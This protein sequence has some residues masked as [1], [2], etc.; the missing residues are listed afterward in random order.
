LC[1]RLSEGIG[2]VRWRKK[3]GRENMKDKQKRRDVG[4]R[5]LGFELSSVVNLT[6][7]SESTTVDI[8]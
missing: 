8:R 2:I 4:R 7:G 3:K 1:A 5:M 6:L